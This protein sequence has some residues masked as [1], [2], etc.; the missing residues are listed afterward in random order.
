MQAHN[1]TYI[2]TREEKRAQKAK[3]ESEAAE[4]RLK[5]ELAAKRAQAT[6]PHPSASPLPADGADGANREEVK[7]ENKLLPSESVVFMEV[8]PPA[9]KQ[10]STAPP[11]VGNNDKADEVCLISPC[12]NYSFTVISRSLYGC[13]SFFRSWNRRKK[14]WQP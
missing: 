12:M 7:Q 10:D 2:R 11:D 13:H 1:I 6:S 9:G 5:Q 8:D 14:L 3:E 4:R